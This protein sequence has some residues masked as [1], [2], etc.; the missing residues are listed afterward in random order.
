MNSIKRILIG[1]SFVT[2]SSVAAAQESD[3]FPG[4]SAKAED[5]AAKISLCDSGLVR[6]VEE[7]NDSVRPIREIVD[8]VRSPQGFAMKQINDHIVHI[9]AWVGY[10]M[11][12]VGS[13]KNKAIDRIR[14]EAKKAV[15]LDRA[16]CAMA[17]PE[18]DNVW[19]E[20]TLDPAANDV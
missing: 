20:F 6:K 9:P 10:A 4:C 7:A 16:A 17:S 11:D 12:P 14:S 13:I 1:L 2:L 15:G 5:A 3:C 18:E 8:I 19:E